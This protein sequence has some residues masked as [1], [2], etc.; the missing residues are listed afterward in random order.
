MLPGHYTR[1]TGYQRPAAATG[2]CEVALVSKAGKSQSC[3]EKASSLTLSL[4]LAALHPQTL[5]PLV[6]APYRLQPL[7]GFLTFVFISQFLNSPFLS[8]L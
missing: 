2:F 5:F 4:P 8:H 3:T 6:P 7:Y 1:G